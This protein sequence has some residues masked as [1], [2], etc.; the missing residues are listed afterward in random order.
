MTLLMFRRVGRY[1]PSGQ[2]LYFFVRVKAESFVDHVHV[3]IH[4]MAEVI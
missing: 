1:F 3:Q 2:G 4:F